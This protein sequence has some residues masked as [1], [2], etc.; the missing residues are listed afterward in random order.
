MN[1]FLHQRDVIIDHGL[2]L[3]GL[4]WFSLSFSFS[5][6]WLYLSGV[7]TDAAAQRV[8]LRGSKLSGAEQT[9]TCWLL[10]THQSTTI[11]GQLKEM[12]W[13][14]RPGHSHRRT[15]LEIQRAQKGQTPKRA[16]HQKQRMS[17]SSSSSRR[18]TTVRAMPHRL[19][20]GTHQ[21]TVHVWRKRTWRT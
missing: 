3:F 20:V 2:V 13:L 14:V 7:T 1:R 4:V 19:L 15:M 16:Q 8:V 6:G 9:Q 10:H 12:L 21:R 5:C 18:V 11:H 17:S